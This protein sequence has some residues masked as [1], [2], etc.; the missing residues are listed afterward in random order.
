MADRMAADDNRSLT[1]LVESL[2]VRALKEGCYML[3]RINTAK[4]VGQTE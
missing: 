3:G 2:I 4:V 1:S